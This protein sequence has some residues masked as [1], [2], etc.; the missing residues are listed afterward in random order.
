MPTLG[1]TTW[2]AGHAPCLEARANALWRDELELPCLIPFFFVSLMYFGF[3]ILNSG[4]RD[5]LVEPISGWIFWINFIYIHHLLIKN[6]FHCGWCEDNDKP[7]LEY[8]CFTFCFQGNPWALN[9]VI[10]DGRASMISNFF[11][12]FQ[13]QNSVYYYYYYYYNNNKYF[14]K[15]FLFKN[16]LK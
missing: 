6:H 13:Y 10:I 15:D 16:I 4:P 7:R 11:L 5:I 12:T 1:V 2:P 9:Y 8:F 14:L 3:A